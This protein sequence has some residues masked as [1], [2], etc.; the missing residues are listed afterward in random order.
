[1]IDDFHD[2]IIKNPRERTTQLVLADWLEEHGDFF[3]AAIRRSELNFIP[4]VE[5]T[6]IW[7]DNKPFNLYGKKI[8]LVEGV[9]FNINYQQVKTGNEY[10]N[11]FVTNGQQI[12]ITNISIYGAFWIDG[13]VSINAFAS[14]LH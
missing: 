6:T 5:K 10:K 1:M 12:G 8:N 13:A 2:Y 14:E 4:D 11:V 9:L 7:I 3:E